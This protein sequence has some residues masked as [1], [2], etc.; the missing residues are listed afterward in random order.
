M[1]HSIKV[2]IIYNHI[3]LRSGLAALIETMGH[4]ICFQ[5]D[6]GNDLE[7]LMIRNLPDIVLIINDIPLA[8]ENDPI[9]WLYEHYP[10]V[11]VAGLSMMDN[12]NTIIRMLKNGADGYI[13]KESRPEQLRVALEAICTKGYHYSESILNRSIETLQ[14]M[15]RKDWFERSPILND[16][17]KEFLRH[18][19]TEMTYKEIAGKMYVSPRTV[20]GYRNNLFEKLKVKSRVGL[21]LY[22]IREG[23]LQLN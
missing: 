7:A 5:S 18:T 15:H 4:S 3:L 20:D 14:L 16:V 17:E 13:L 19:G 12:E 21:V 23:I 22:A 8:C 2:A 10:A 11:R 9:V 1:S 6:T